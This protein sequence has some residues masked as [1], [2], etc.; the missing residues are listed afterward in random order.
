MAET[1]EQINE[2][3]KRINEMSKNY[4]VSQKLSPITP[5]VGNES[6]PFRTATEPADTG[7][8]GA[9]AGFAGTQD[10]L[11]KETEALRQQREKDAGS[12]LRDYLRSVTDTKTEAQLREEQYGSKG[13]VF[14]IQ[15]ELDA[16]DQ[17]IREKQHAL[18]RETERIEKNDAGMLRGA[19]ADEVARVERESYREQAD[20]Y[21]IRDGIQGRFD[22]AQARADATIDRIIS[23][24]ELKNETLRF[25]YEENKDLFTKSEQREF[26]LKQSDRERALDR[27]ADEMKQISDLS[28]EAHISGA[29]VATVLA[30]R[31]AKS[32]SEALQL[33]G[34]YVGVAERMSIRKAQLEIDKLE[35]ELGGFENINIDGL[36]ESGTDENVLA[37]I[38]KSA[39]YDKE[40]DASQIESIEQIQRTLGSM[41]ALN[42][43]L[44]GVADSKT[45]GALQRDFKNLSTGRITGRVLQ[46]KTAISEQKDAKAIQAIITGMLPTVA[47]GIFGE[48]GVLT[49]TDIERYRGTLARFENT[50][51]E[52]KVIQLVMLDTLSKAYGAKLETLARAQ[53]NVSGFS[54]Q[55]IATRK[56]IE[57]IKL[58][59]GVTGLEDVADDELFGADTSGASDTSNASFWEQFTPNSPTGISF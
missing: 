23:Q 57:D 21:I 46:L 26:E 33:G 49:D 9:L 17:T 2:R 56:K 18:T 50:P 43:Y 48:V 10:A 59:M 42:T 25:V 22:S 35:Q 41:E 24:Q 53:R 29:P 28:I 19:V 13:G 7:I 37:W 44:F 16:I 30:M 55:Y 4:G 1:I 5:D 32:V 11:V 40:V 34:Q 15:D 39:E 36:Y 52:N 45:E 38:Q 31:N 54:G 6:A 58:Q 3:V 47:R 27:Q 51:D 20:L 12:S 14:D 8:S